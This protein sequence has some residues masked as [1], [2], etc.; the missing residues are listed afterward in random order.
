[1]QRSGFCRKSESQQQGERREQD[2]KRNNSVFL[3]RSVFPP[4]E[5]RKIPRKE[6]VREEGREKPWIEG[7]DR[8]ACRLKN[9]RKRTKCINQCPR[10]RGAINQWSVAGQKKICFD[11]PAQNYFVF[12]VSVPVTTV[13]IAR[14]SVP[15]NDLPVKGIICVLGVFST[16]CY[17]Q[18]LQPTSINRKT[19][20][21][22]LYG[23]T[24]HL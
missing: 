13:S 21:A 3:L 18:T 14:S 23:L 24:H 15:E 1:L 8:W 22:K 5:R 10:A 20:I 9:E 4:L 19:G 17:F 12:C 7:V 16:F 11:H 2:D 6:M